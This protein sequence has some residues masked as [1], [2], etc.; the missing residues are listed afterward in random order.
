[1]IEDSKG[2][3]RRET[4]ER[5]VRIQDRRAET[6]D[7]D[8]RSDHLRQEISAR[9]E[10]LRQRKETLNLAKELHNDEISCASSRK[11]ELTEEM[12]RLT[13][14]RSRFSPTRTTLIS[15]LSFIFPIDLLSPPDLLFTIL[16]VPLPIPI[17]PTDPAPPLTLPSHKEVTEDAVATALGYAA[18]V[19]QLLAAYLGKGLVYPVTCIGSRSLIK[20]NI[21]AMVGPKMFPLF[22]KGVDTYRFE[23]GVFLLNKNIE[24]LMSD[25]DLRALDMRHTLP[26]LKNLLLTLTD[27][28][29]AR[30]AVSQPPDS[31]ILSGLETPP[32]A[33]SPPALKLTPS[34][35]DGESP[36][37]SV[38]EQPQENSSPITS[39]SATP[40][41]AAATTNDSGTFSKYPYPKISLGFPPLPGF[42]R[43]RNPS[44][45]RPSDPPPAISETSAEV[46]QNGNASTNEVADERDSDGSNSDDD[47]H[48]TIQGVSIDAVDEADPAIKESL[49]PPYTNG[50]TANGEAHQEKVLGEGVSSHKAPAI[51]AHSG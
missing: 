18:Q 5:E 6:E 11:E 26:N 22:S 17:F 14:L 48:R 23:Y 2:A 35:P 4:S 30:L 20:D 44:A 1:M 37:E 16:S 46:H 31:P 45:S 34:S 8:R 7:I 13:S 49:E 47:D 43:S 19:V 27:G 3:L 33:Q 12:N 51:V 32:R 21:S 9:K 15:T 38:V 25:R 50:V 24:M 36:H 39:G 42:F 28:E 41:A 40:T 10:K 29:G